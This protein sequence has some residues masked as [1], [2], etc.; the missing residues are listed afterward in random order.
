MPIT[1]TFIEKEAVVN[2]EIDRLRHA[3]TQSLLTRDDVI[4]VASV[5]AIY[6]IGNPAEYARVI[7]RLEVGAVE[8]RT[9]LLR[10]LIEIHFTRTTADLTQGSFRALGNT[11]EIHPSHEQVIYRLV[12]AGAKIGRIDLLDPITR[13]IR[14]EEVQEVIIFPAKHFVTP[15]SEIK[16][17]VKDIKGELEV[18]LKELE[19]KKNYNLLKQMKI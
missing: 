19:K 2:E 18:Q 17:A 6:G 8:S 14:E 4:I 7:L 3:A 15:E 10:K 13:E 9:G 16:R 11:I 12:F 5:S 1:D